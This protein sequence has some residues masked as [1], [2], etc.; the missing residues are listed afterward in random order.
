MP[1]ALIQTKLTPPQ[2]SRLVDRP[3]LREALDGLKERR[4]ALVS[5]PAGFGKTTVVADWIRSSG[6]SAGWI[7]LD[8]GDNDVV[9]FLSYFTE[10]LRA[11]APRAASA[12]RQMLEG[13][14]P[15]AVEPVLTVLVNG[16]HS[17]SRDFLI[18]LDDYHVINEQSV[19]DSVSFLLERLPPRVRLVVT[20][21][22]DPPLP[23]ALLKSR[24]QLVE[25]RAADLRFTPGE[26]E[27]FF[28]AL[29]GLDLRDSDVRTLAGRT[30]GWIAGMRLAAA[31]LRASRNA[32]EYVRRF[33]GSDRHVMDYLSEEVL[34]RLP[35]HTR[36]FLIKTSV[37]DKLCGPLCD[38]LTGAAGGADTLRRVEAEGLFLEPL[39][40]QR[41]WYRYHPLF[42]GILRL[43][44]GAGGPEAV[45]G[46][47]RK[48]SVWYGR[49]GMSEEAIDHALAGKDHARA[50]E[51]IQAA[52]DDMMMHCR[53]A[54]LLRWIEAIPSEERSRY[55]LLCV[56]R[57]S[58]LLVIG[59]TYADVLQALCEAEACAEAGSISA[60]LAALK[61]FISYLRQQP[62]ESLTLARRA[63]SAL[64]DS[65][66][67]LKGTMQWI[68]GILS[69]SAGDVETAEYNLGLSIRSARRAGNHFTLAESCNHL[70]ELSLMRGSLRDAERLCRE[71]LELSSDGESGRFP[72]AAVPLL[73]LAKIALERNDLS[74]AESLLAEASAFAEQWNTT[75]RLK[76]R[77][78]AGI[79]AAA[80]GDFPAATEQ[81][82]LTRELAAGYDITEID[83]RLVEADAADMAVRTGRMEE[84]ERWARARGISGELERLKA[85]GVEPRSYH[86]VHEREHLVFARYQLALGRPADALE[87]ARLLEGEAEA[88]GLM[89]S[90]LEIRAVSALAL[91]ALGRREEAL[92][93]LEMPL[94]LA[95]AEGFIR[96]FVDSGIPM[97]RLLE[98]AARGGIHAECAGKI[99]AAFPAEKT[100]RAAVSL[101]DGS[102]I[103]PL[104]S[105]ETLIVRLLSEGLSNK[106][107][108]DR[109]FISV[110]TVKWH[111]SNIYSKLGVK[112][113]TQAVARARGLGII[114]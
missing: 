95:E 35:E 100:L 47:H 99:L 17:L 85:K 104:S 83:D 92:A 30:E 80:R 54:T 6:L 81:V 15:I 89:R 56:A 20:T 55:P 60:E 84:A 31:S 61:S 21:R 26:A 4:L 69:L 107:I 113:R 5:A 82:R 8:P 109:E 34:R 14:R 29:M 18:V 75:T 62:R 58:A 93:A 44:L 41:T 70:S 63:V 66:R 22:A 7:T 71:A 51:L 72:V 1:E 73:Q 33:G 110:Q 76:C 111:T 3:R 2:H 11:Q 74:A 46:L 42:S 13:T 39:D 64:S 12:A 114:P 38:A 87:T 112:S 90:L 28:N 86:I 19:H 67:F 101:P 50:A 43:R 53:A 102:V 37:V 10:A 49:N 98:E 79:I 97:A 16:A 91:D 40:D 105:R 68:L 96:V 94:A 45:E 77:K 32:A 27:E 52:A 9:R 88:K 103:E 25:V 78:L 48:A 24:G 23:L 57:V 108:A 59:K 65:S 106:E 36:S